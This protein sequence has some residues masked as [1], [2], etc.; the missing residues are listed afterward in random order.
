MLH[1]NVGL[2]A[3]T[4]KNAADPRIAALAAKVGYVI[5]AKNPYPDAYTGHLRVTFA[6]GR[7]LEERQPHFR[8]GHNE[9]LTRAELEEKFRG[10]CA[11]GGWDE[12][13]AGRWLAFASGAF[14]ARAIDLK[15][16]RG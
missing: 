2:E 8:G 5:D 11:Y 13:R 16:F 15:E 14:D 6:D 1:G 12:A 10:N 7:V 3:F 4:D 9:P